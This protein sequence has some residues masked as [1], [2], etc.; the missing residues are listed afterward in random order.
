MNRASRRLPVRRRD[1]ATSEE[2]FAEIAIRAL[3][4]ALLPR[5]LDCA[6]LG[7]DAHRR[8][9]RE[10]HDDLGIVKQPR[11]RHAAERAISMCTDGPVAA[12]ER[13]LAQNI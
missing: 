11:S 10:Q 8:T 1:R 7:L 6:E 3:D 12:S 5:F 4:L 2:V 9:Q 13:V